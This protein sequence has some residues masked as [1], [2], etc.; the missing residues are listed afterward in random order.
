METGKQVL[1][2]KM[3]TS[4]FSYLSQNQEILWISF[5]TMITFAKKHLYLLVTIG[6]T[7]MPSY[8]L[9]TGYN[10]LYYRSVKNVKFNNFSISAWQSNTIW[11][12]TYNM[13][14]I[15]LCFINILRVQ[16]LPQWQLSWLYVR[17]CLLKSFCCL[18]MWYRFKVLILRNTYL[19]TL[20]ST[21]K[22]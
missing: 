12:E 15:V 8:K 18:W 1:I 10:N 11:I 9:C 19:I 7:G 4:K 17:D 22:W 6:F 21:S 13:I 16:G 2:W 14:L 3:L 20:E 5:E